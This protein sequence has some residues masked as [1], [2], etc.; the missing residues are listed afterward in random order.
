LNSSELVISCSSS[1]LAAEQDVLRKRLLSVDELGKA[2]GEMSL[3][4]ASY[5]S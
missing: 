5:F 3:L 2:L 1:F 4:S